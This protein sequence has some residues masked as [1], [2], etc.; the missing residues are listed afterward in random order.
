MFQSSNKASSKIKRAFGC[1]KNRPF[2]QNRVINNNEY[3][4][5]LNQ[6]VSHLDC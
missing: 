6:I 3:G 5:E 2:T 1:R 4:S